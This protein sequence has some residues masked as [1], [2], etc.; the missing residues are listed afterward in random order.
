MMSGCLVVQVE[1]LLGDPSKAKKELDWHCK[2][3]FHEL[4][5]DM[6]RADLAEVRSGIAEHDTH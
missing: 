5:A 2:I 1:Q 3:R 4:V 6:M